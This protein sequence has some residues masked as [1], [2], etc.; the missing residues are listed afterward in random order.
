MSEVRIIKQNDREIE[1]SS[2]SMTRIAGV[3]KNIVGAEG[4]HLSVASIPPGRKASP[5]IHTNCESA[6]YIIS[7]TGEFLV[8]E[9]LQKTLFFE[10]GDFFHVP[11]MAPHQPIN[12]GNV[13]VTM[14]VARNAP[15]EIVKEI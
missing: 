7:G 2:G 5:H 10:P 14:V 4:I 15:E 6:I 8:G 1:I 3:S 9:N 11:S 12:T 13:E